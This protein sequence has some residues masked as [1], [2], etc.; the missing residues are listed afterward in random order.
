MVCGEGSGEKRLF[1]V[2]S[3]L[4]G[5]FFVSIG[6]KNSGLGPR[7]LDVSSRSIALRP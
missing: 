4:V 7:A 3:M 6:F 1:S 2:G 5:G